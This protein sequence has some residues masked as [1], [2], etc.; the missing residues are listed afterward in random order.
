M[1]VGNE[2]GS[3]IKI[4]WMDRDYGFGP[5]SLFRQPTTF[6]RITL[7]DPTQKQELQT[8]LVNQRIKK[9]WNNS[10]W[11]KKNPSQAY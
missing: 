4:K 10:N 7:V 6:A 3:H 11:V 5:T 1:V 2:Y 8:N 9:L